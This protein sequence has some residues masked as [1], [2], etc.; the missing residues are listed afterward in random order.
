MGI[1]KPYAGVVYGKLFVEVVL[2]GASEQFFSVMMCCF[3]LQ[4]FDQY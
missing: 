1:D 2:V 4:R 3:T